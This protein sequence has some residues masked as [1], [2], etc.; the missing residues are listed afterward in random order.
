[1][2][3]LVFLLD[4]DN[5]LINNDQVKND[6]N[7]HLE[8]ELGPNLTARF[9]EIY[10]Q[11]RQERGVVDIPLSLQR[12]REQTSLS[13]L[14]E[15][16]FSHVQSIFDNYPFFYALYPHTLETLRHLRTIGLTVIVSDG[17]QIFQP[18][19]IY[20]SDLAETVEGRV[21]IFTHKQQHLNEILQ[22]YPADHYVMVDDK[23]DILVDSKAIMGQRL[24]TVFVQQGH[25]AKQVPDNFT[26]DISVLHIGDLRNFTKEQFLNS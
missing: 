2:Q 4:V 25:Y 26:P 11:A 8:V 18:E 13:E 3:T 19:K 7:A 20:R 6:F 21:L 10:E 17:D 16:T 9:W 23:P 12:L 14:D 1:M 22:K 24:T 15:Q 5:T